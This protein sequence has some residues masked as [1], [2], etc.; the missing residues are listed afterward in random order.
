M[1]TLPIELNWG[2]DRDG[3]RLTD[4]GNYGSWITGNGGDLVRTRPLRD[5]DLHFKVFADLKTPDQL[6]KFISNYGLLYNT[7]YKSK[8]LS[9]YSV[10][11]IF[12]HLQLDDGKPKRKESDKPLEG[13]SVSEHLETAALMSTVMKQ[14]VR[15]WK[16]TPRALDLALSTRF[17]HEPLG[18]IGLFGDK[19]RGMRLTF[20]AR[21]L[22]DAMWLQLAHRVSGGGTFQSCGF[23]GLS[24]E[25]GVGT[26]RRADAKFCS[27]EHQIKFNSR[28][29]SKDR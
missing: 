13:E 20:T 14:T 22:M 10:R 7:D 27:D 16:R 18:E 24:F 29:R 25:S 2:R 12:G 4:H 5:H 6:L 17:N 28:K 9:R 8:L 3:Y 19:K 21:S 15:G 11:P 23:C 26:G 1:T